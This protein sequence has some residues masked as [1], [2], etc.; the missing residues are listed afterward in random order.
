MRK[1]TEQRASS[2][3]RANRHGKM[4]PRFSSL[5]KKQSK[6]DQIRQLNTEQY[7]DL[8]PRKKSQLTTQ[9]ISTHTVLNL[10][11]FYHFKSDHLVLIPQIA[12]HPFYDRLRGP[13]AFSTTKFNRQ[14][15]SNIN[16][17]NNIITQ[18]TTT[19]TT[20]VSGGS[21]RTSYSSKK[22]S[23]RSRQIHDTTN[24]HEPQQTHIIRPSSLRQMTN[25]FD[26]MAC[27]QEVSRLEIFFSV[28]FACASNIHCPKEKK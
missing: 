18:T 9:K 27:F 2:A 4:S 1:E 22:R 23:S 16:S 24:N 28:F 26:S 12:S 11:E 14:A 17:N 6:E 3:N 25:K 19:T 13:S 20:V 5:D 21:P 7:L 10:P 15:I 8:L